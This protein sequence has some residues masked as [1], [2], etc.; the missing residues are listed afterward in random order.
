M[1]RLSI[2][3]SAAPQCLEIPEG[4]ERSR[5]GSIH[6]QPGL[7]LTVTDGEAEIVLRNVAGVRVSKQRAQP[8]VVAQQPEVQLAEVVAQPEV[9]DTSAGLEVSRR[10]RKDP[11]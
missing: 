11:Q 8:E 7:T 3:S 6:I 2:P 4:I 5:K 9:I 10:K 1:K